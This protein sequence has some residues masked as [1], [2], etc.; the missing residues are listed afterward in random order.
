[1]GRE[2]GTQVEVHVG[3]WVSIAYLASLL[4]KPHRMDK[5][6]QDLSGGTVYEREC[7][8]CTNP[9]RLNPANKAYTQH[10]PVDSEDVSLQITRIH[11]I[12]LSISTNAVMW[13]PYS[14]TGSRTCGPKHRWGRRGA[15]TLIS[16]R[17][18]WKS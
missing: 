8:E 7:K 5:V 2:T 6:G 3:R 10:V 16:M 12:D 11:G 14:R 15:M 18:C 1:M 17:S 13:V 4:A 9:L